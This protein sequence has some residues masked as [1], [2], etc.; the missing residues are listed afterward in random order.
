M[1]NH[2]HGL[3]F[4]CPEF[5]PAMNELLPRAEQCSAPTKHLPS[6]NYGLLSKI[7]KS[8]KNIVTKE[9][10]TFDPTFSWQRS[11]HDHIIRNE[12]DLQSHWEYILNN[13]IAWEMDKLNPNFDHN[14]AQREH[15]IK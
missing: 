7:V 4:Y 10:R 6:K 14:N 13:P 11:F 8:Y 5:C 3:I 15:K 9:I 12:K 1:P 2:I